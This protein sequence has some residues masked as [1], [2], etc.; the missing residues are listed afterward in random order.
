MKKAINNKF[1]APAAINGNK[2]RKTSRNMP[3][4]NDF[5]GESPQIFQPQITSTQK[6]ASPVKPKIVFLPTITST[7]KQTPDTENENAET[8]PHPVTAD[9]SCSYKTLAQTQVDPILSQVDTF[10]TANSS[11]TIKDKQPD[12]S[13]NS[14]A[15]I[16]ANSNDESNLYQIFMEHYFDMCKFD[17]HFRPPWTS[18]VKQLHTFLP[19][20]ES[21]NFLL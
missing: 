16:R 14:E 2:R 4:T 17:A 19:S 18:Q 1:I 20:N 15:T 6:Q 5:D 11:F 13:G 7:Q 9:S 21:S 10:L 3:E 8:Q 12:T